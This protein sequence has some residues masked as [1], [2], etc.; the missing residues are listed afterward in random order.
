MDKK[1][2]FSKAFVKIAMTPSRIFDGFGWI[3][4]EPKNGFKNQYWR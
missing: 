1:I 4:H 3:F 2:Y